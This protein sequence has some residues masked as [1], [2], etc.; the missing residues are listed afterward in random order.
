M[1]N[2][3]ID[4]LWRIFSSASEDGK[5]VREEVGK[6]VGKK[7]GNMDPVPAAVAFSM[8]TSVVAE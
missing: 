6:E 8:E 2:P 5:E 1:V 3:S 4:G 7:V